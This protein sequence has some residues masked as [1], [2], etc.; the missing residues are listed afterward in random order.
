MSFGNPIHSN[1]TG[2]IGFSASFKTALVFRQSF[3][4][5]ESS[6]NYGFL[7]EKNFYEKQVHLAFAD[8]TPDRVSRLITGAEE[9]QT[10]AQWLT[11]ADRSALL[12]EQKDTIAVSL[13]RRTPFPPST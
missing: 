7:L 1:N 13:R 4:Y 6:I 8:R 5:D 11:T 10:P 2:I 3:D 9:V 12:A